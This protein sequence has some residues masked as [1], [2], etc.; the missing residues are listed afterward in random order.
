[1]FGDGL[2]KLLPEGEDGQALLR[3]LDLEPIR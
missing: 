1:M 3:L 2:E